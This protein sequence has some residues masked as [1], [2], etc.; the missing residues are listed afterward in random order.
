M[1]RRAS[2]RLRSVAARGGLRDF[3]DVVTNDE[4]LA[5]FRGDPDMSVDEALEIVM[6]KDVT[7]G[8]PWVKHLEK[9]TVG[10]NQLDPEGISQISPDYKNSHCLERSPVFLMTWI[11][12]L[13]RLETA[14]SGFHS[15]LVRKF[16]HQDLLD[17]LSN[18]EGGVRDDISEALRGSFSQQLY[19]G[20]FLDPLAEGTV[21]CS[22]TPQ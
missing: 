15:G 1:D 22:T 19:N 12:S 20:W 10:L 8:H 3:K 6:S 17:I 11:E 7:K 16:S 21:P 14:K 5:A 18:V 4:A 9:V 2:Q 13:P